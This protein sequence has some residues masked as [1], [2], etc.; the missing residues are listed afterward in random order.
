MDSVD[1]FAAGVIGFTLGAAP[2][3]ARE[4]LVHRLAL[5][6][7]ER[8]RQSA[9]E[10]R[11]S[12]RQRETLEAFQLALDRACRVLKD[13]SLHDV[14]AF[15]SGQPWRAASIP[16][17]MNVESGE[18]L[19]RISTLG[20]RMADERLRLAASAVCLDALA[21]A[22]AASAESSK[23]SCEALDETWEETTEYLGQLVRD[24]DNV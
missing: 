9:A 16:E 14:E 1:S 15:E 24:L 22:G 13:I 23:T 7:E 10:L 8:A 2:L 17:G 11:R 12:D 19:T 5:R 18:A 4:L 3:V 21:I 6:R 20:A